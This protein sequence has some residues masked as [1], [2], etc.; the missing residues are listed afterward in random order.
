VLRIERELG[1]RA[2]F[3]GAALFADAGITLPFR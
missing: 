3:I 1:T 2:R